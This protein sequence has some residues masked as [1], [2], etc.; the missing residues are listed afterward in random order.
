M[1]ASAAHDHRVAP[2]RASDA[3][4]S[5]GRSSATERADVEATPPAHSPTRG[6]MRRRPQAPQSGLRAWQ[7]RRPWRSRLRWSSSSAPGGVSAS[8]ASWSSSK[9]ARGPQQPEPRA[10]A[11]DVRVDR[12]V[13]QAEAEQEH[14]RG[15]LAARR[16]AARTARSRLRPRSRASRIQSRLSGSPIARRIAWMR[17]DLTFEIPPGR[18]ASSTSAVGAS[19]TASHDDAGRRRRRSARAGAGTRRRGCGRS[20]SARARSGSARRAVA[21]AGAPTGCRRARAGARARGARGRASVRSKGT[22]CTPLS[23]RLAMADVERH[24]DEIDGMPVSWLAASADGDAHRLRPRRPE[25]RA[26]VDA[27]SRANRRDRPDMPGFGDSIKAVHLPVFDSRAMTASSS[28]S[29]TGSGSTASTSSSTTGAPPRS[30]SRSACPSASSASSLIN[31]LPLFD[32]YGWSRAARV[33]RARPC[34]ASSRWAASRCA[35]CGARCA[36]R[37]ASRS[38]SASCARCTPSSTSVP[39]ARSSSSIAACGPARSRRPAPGSHGSTLRR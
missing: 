25:Q 38:R 36:T 10:D 19:R 7:V 21:G 24:T 5:H 30:R 37:T 23:S 29:S 15:G 20:C 3:H 27:V 8:I 26:H 39:S 22:A 2:R 9:G 14:A 35:C 18:I 17:T 32:G 1:P 33:L 11:R 4:A 13:A 6:H 16:P 31:A 28:G 34:S 12:D